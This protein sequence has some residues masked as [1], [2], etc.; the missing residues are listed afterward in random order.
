MT[1][2]TLTPIEQGGQRVLTTAQLAEAYETTA[3][4]INDNF[5]NNRKHYIEGKH[6][7][8]LTG[9]ELKA[10]KNYPEN[11]GVVDKRTPCLY[12]WTERG[13]L[14]HAKSLNTDK[15]WEVHDFLIENYFRVQEIK[16]SYADILLKMYQK[17]N[18]LESRLNQLES[19]LL[20]SSFRLPKK[21]SLQS[22]QEN[23]VY[24]MEKLEQSGEITL[25]KSKLLR[26][27]RI[28]KAREL[29]EALKLLA[30]NEYISYRKV[31][32]ARDGNP[33]EVITILKTDT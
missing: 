9:D 1:N 4:T 16:T 17:Q 27:C 22:R 5:G 14:L 23:A 21:S 30:E 20:E 7:Y 12:L 8:C 2:F 19:K 32:H 6:F 3:K 11:F 31:Y 33:K 24:I 28:L 25:T 13:S 26:M 29:T 18:E 15:A 10:F